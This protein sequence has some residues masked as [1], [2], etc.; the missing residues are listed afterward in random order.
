[1]TRTIMIWM[2][3]KQRIGKTMDEALFYLSCK[4]EIPS[5]YSVVLYE[6]GER[7]RRSGIQKLPCS[8]RWKN[9]DWVLLLPVPI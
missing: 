9:M 8:L 5:G 2:M 1:M 3:K 6:L 4:K 7:C